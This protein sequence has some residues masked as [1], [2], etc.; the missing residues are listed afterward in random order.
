MRN[1]ER[2]REVER[3]RSRGVEIC[4]EKKIEREKEREL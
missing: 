1:I 3:N 2:E 4:T